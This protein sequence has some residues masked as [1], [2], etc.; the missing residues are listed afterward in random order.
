VLVHGQ[1]GQEGL[2]F[3]RAHVF[4]MAFVVEQDEALDP[5]HVGFFGADRI[6]LDADGIA[7]TSTQ[8]SAGLIQELFRLHGKSPRKGLDIQAIWAY[9]LPWIM[10]SGQDSA[11]SSRQADYTER[12][13]KT[14]LGGRI[15]G[16]YLNM[17]TGV[18]GGIGL[19]NSWAAS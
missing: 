3:G 5:V 15:D 7:H 19:L 2:D 1:V 13:R 16:I 10:R 17:Q 18:I 4:G 9:T 11:N 6:V 8:L 14:Q 12:F